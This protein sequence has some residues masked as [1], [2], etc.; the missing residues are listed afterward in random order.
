MYKKR[1]ITF[2]VIV[3]MGIGLY[4]TYSFYRFFFKPNTAFANEESYVFI[5][6]EFRFQDV[7][8]ELEDLLISV[9][10]FKTAAEKKGYNFRI[11]GGKFILKKGLNNHEIVNVLR[12][13]ST[14]VRVIFN[15]QERLENLAGR[16]AQ[17]IAPDSL[18]LLNAFRDPEFLKLND[19]DEKSAL[20]MYL[21][22]SYDLFWNTSPEGFR[23]RMLKEYKRFWNLERIEKAKALNL[24]PIEVISLAAI[25]QKE[26]VK[27]DERKKIAG[28]YLNRLKKRM[29]LDADPTV[30]YSL[31]EKYQ[32]FD[33]IIR[34]VL[35]KDLKIVSPYNTYKNKGVPP[36]PITMPDFSSI[37][38]V[39]DS[40]KHNYLYFV[41]NPKEPGYHTF[42]KTHRAHIRNSRVYHR[43]INSQKLYR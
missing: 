36:G 2:I 31:K 8:K 25:V 38:A 13:K 11:K 5:E 28:V 24:S 9:D 34:R 35:R 32:N 41:A 3:G 42:A 39:L 16:V 1:I 37:N 23:D 14:A 7:V 29:H 40:E 12:G 17:Q 33:T 26:T 27:V 15:N 43:W 20:S 30:V 6:N 4:F 10:D 21:P 18:S 19:F 22:N